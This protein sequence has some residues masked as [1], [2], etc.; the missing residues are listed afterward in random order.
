ME[1]RANSQS[2]SPPDEMSYVRLDL[3]GRN[4]NQD[5]PSNGETSTMLRRALSQGRKPRVCVVGAGV[6]GMRCAQVLGE[7]GIDVTILEAR[8][9]TGGRVGLSRSRQ[10]L[11]L[12]AVAG[13]RCIKP[14]SA[15]I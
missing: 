14:R 12:I 8:N 3:N 15:G 13:F 7:K 1:G 5:L 6:A 9:R 4:S 2:Y 11:V 10:G